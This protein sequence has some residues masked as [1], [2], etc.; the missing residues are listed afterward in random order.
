[1]G[2][3]G[4]GGQDLSKMYRFLIVIFNYCVHTFT[5]METEI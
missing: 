3:E 5:Q 2:G 4:G 1:M